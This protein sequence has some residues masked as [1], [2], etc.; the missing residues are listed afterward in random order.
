MD[1]RLLRTFAYA[2]RLGSF[3]QAAERLFLAQPTVTVHVS[4]LE[5][6]LGYPLFERSRS[7][8]S[9][10]PAGRRFLPH[11]LTVLE[12]LE[13]GM[14]D[15]VTWSQ[16]YSSRLAIIASPL[17]AATALPPLLRQFTAA[18][19]GVE[20][21]L[22]VRQ[23]LEIGPALKA[24]Q[25]DLG[26]SL[27]T[28]GDWGLTCTSLYDD[29]VIL[30]A[31]HDG[32]DWDREAPDAA[33]LLERYLLLT[34]NHPEYWDDL[35]LGLR[36]RGLRI[37]TMRVSE[38]HVTKR[39]VEEGL[40]V[41]FLPARVVW[42]ELVEGRLLEVPTPQMMLPRAHTYLVRP[43]AEGSGPAAAA[44]AESVLRYYGLS[45]NGAIQRSQ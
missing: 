41:S 7:G 8:V 22:D 6:Q 31:P 40:G 30:V 9:L 37:R 2:A 27:M 24:G 39:L 36:Q 43:G 16:G 17:I 44:F 35:L 15:L 42:R 1:L 14:E 21:S 29:P 23:S 38:M 13:A 28:P 10:T 32:R 12:A 3:T 18:S 34:H 45:A 5:E 11:A 25:A 4:R 33:E 26:L 20:V 19:P